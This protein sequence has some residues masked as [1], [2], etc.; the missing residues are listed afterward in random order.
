MKTKRILC[1]ILAAVLILSGLAML[2]ACGANSSRSADF[3]IEDGVLTKYT[4]SAAH[5]S[6]PK[7][8]TSI[9]S[10]VFFN[11][12]EIESVKM[13]DNVTQIG[14]AAFYG[15]TNLKKLTLSKAVSYIDDG[16]FGECDSLTSFTIPASVQ[17][18]IEG[19]FYGSDGLTAF[20][21]EDGNASFDAVDGVLYTKLHDA[22][23]AY[24][25][26]KADS[27]CT[28]DEAATYIASWAFFGAKNL[29]A[30]NLPDTLEKIGQE[31][32]YNC[33]LTSLT[34]PSALTE[35]GSGAFQ[36]CAGIPEV[37]IPAG[38]IEV[39]SRCFGDCT[40]L[41]NVVL[42]DGIIGLAQYAFDGCTDLESINIPESLTG[43]FDTCF[44]GC[45]KLTLYCA[46][47]SPIIEYAEANGIAYKTVE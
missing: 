32:F 2:S 21:V 19:A 5:V 16:A 43:I 14:Q 17:F 9:G 39:P 36:G 37:E 11:H 33:G 31:A 46:P 7:S 25:A 29:T 40:G 34:L 28:V 13:T 8:V 45:G 20:T 15:C 41:K 10:F 35:I 24:P 22:L 4:G 1:C 44:Q 38:M 23:V 47:G 42:P 26:A 18:V 30:V 27:T 3:V 6:I 12:T